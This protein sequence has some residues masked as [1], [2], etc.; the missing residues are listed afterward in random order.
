[1]STEPRDHVLAGIE[2]TAGISL[3]ELYNH[4]E[5]D[6]GRF[7]GGVE[8]PPQDDG[9]SHT[10]E[11]DISRTPEDLAERALLKRRDTNQTIVA[12]SAFAL[13]NSNCSMGV[14]RYSKKRLSSESHDFDHS[15]E[16]S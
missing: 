10:P 9:I 16:S 12:P 8:V 2:E 15:D 5:D 3:S 4:D 1:M 6:S 7:S 11:E 13:A 14:K